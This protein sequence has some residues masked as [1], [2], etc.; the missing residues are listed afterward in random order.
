MG[1]YLL[2]E[3]YEVLEAIE[4]EDSSALEEELGDLFFVLLFQA[5]LAQEA[6]SFSLASCLD[7]IADKMVVRHPHVFG[8]GKLDN[9]QAVLEAWERRKQA[10]GRRV[11]QGVPRALPG[12]ARA[13][14]LTDKAATVGFDWDHLHE[15]MAKVEEEL[16][17]LREAMQANNQAHTTEEMG[18]VL[19]ALV[20]LARR[21]DIDAEG[22]IQGTNRKFERRF[23]YIE[24]TLEAK[25]RSVHDA[26]LEEMDALWNEA[27]RIQKAT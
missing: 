16:G 6:G 10:Q 19:F 13:Q 2:E 11:L 3:V 20:N 4:D 23:A 17:E 14:R 12:L 18:D 26:D 5:Q 27:K 25:G 9:A 8:E 7:K 1:R 15:V 21:L 22:A 24:Q